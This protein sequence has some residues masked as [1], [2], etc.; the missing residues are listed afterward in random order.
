[1][2][3]VTCRPQAPA[4]S[5]STGTSSSD[6]STAGTG[7]ATRGIQTV[8][9]SLT[10]VSGSSGAPHTTLPDGATTGD[11]LVSVVSTYQFASVTFG[12][13]WVTAYDV[14]TPSGVHLVAAWKPVGAGDSA[15]TATVSPDTQVSM[16]TAAFRHVDLSAP[17]EAAKAAPGAV[18]PGVVVQTSGA[19]LVLSHASTA[20]Q[21]SPSPPA[22]AQLAAEANNGGN[23]EVAVA[24]QASAAIG[25]T[26]GF[27]WPAAP[28]SSSVATGTLA[29]RPAVPGSAPGV[30]GD[31]PSTTGSVSAGS[32]SVATSTSVVPSTTSAAADP[33]T[34]V[35]VAPPA[36]SAPGTP[37]PVCGSATLAGPSTAPAGA[38]WLAPT[39]NLGDV[40][41]A[42]PAHTTYWLAPG[43]YRLGTGA[44]DQVIPHSGD[45][46]V[47][48]PGAILDGQHKNLY[49]FT[50]SA[51][52]VTISHLTVQNFGAAGQNNNEGVVN[53]DAAKNWTITANTIQANAGSGLMIGSGDRVTGNCI[54]NNGQYAFNAYSPDGVSQVV[55]D[56]NEI[57]GNNTDDWE[58]RQPGC[59][60]TG[61]G[62]FWATNGATVTNNY[63]HDNKGV[64]LWADTNNA[65]FLFQGNY[66][67]GNDAEGLMYETS[68]NAAIINNT[69]V[70][71]ALVKGPTN[72]GFPA[73]AIYLSE[74]GSDTR[75]AGPYGASFRISGNMFT[76]NWAG[77][78]A[79]ENADRFAG[80]PANTSSGTT[81]L[82]NPTVA[83]EAACATASTVAKAPYLDDC[84]WKTQNVQMD[85]NS[86]TLNAT[87]IAKCTAA[88]GCG[89]NGLFSNYGTY[90]NWS[91]YKG[92]VVQDHLTLHQNNLW[93]NNTY[94]GPW[95]F[96][97]K[98]GGNVVPWATWRAAPYG[99][100]AGS[101]L[102]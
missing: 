24:V 35:T 67:S 96:I 37:R 47:A 68:Y 49:A 42:H 64:G 38:V 4:G 73:S 61:G 28:A 33:A 23:S 52:D 10:F 77:I 85:H 99:Q 87:G 90:P 18:S 45:T 63:V 31:A 41:A 81:T 50:G 88:N 102:S 93:Q 5:G 76:D 56:S 57:S 20:W 97:I 66:I 84:R 75:V 27:A 34:T 26:P 94:R 22:N 65:N 29:I 100:D 55:L 12:A 25:A 9:R 54:R 40:V 11:L 13:G 2:V 53:H 6:A 98:A 15:V 46:V 62:K 51:T 95:G 14:S 21:Y 16:A 8:G 60:C 43:T 91:P 17:V 59:G 72:P 48:A 32:S 79:W 83:T 70:R 78:I 36:G 39:Q 86:F 71:N 7:A 58:A 74:S 19:L 89:F 80:S 82:V 1:V 101:T 30:V 69:F 44:Y 3:T 92:E